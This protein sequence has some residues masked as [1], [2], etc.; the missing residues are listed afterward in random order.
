MKFRAA[1]L[2]VRTGQTEAV[3]I[4]FTIEIKEEEKWT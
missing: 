3:T 2:T 4:N 1:S